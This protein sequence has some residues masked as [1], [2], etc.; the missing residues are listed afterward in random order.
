MT[1]WASSSYHSSNNRVQH[2]HPSL[3]CCSVNTTCNIYSF[4]DTS[5]SLLPLH[6]LLINVSVLIHFLPA[7]CLQMTSGCIRT[8]ANLSK[9][10][11]GLLPLQKTINSWIFVD[12]RS[13]V[14]QQERGIS[15]RG[16]KSNFS[17]PSLSI[18]CAVAEDMVQELGPFHYSSHIGYRGNPSWDWSKA[19]KSPVLISNDW[20]RDWVALKVFEAHFIK[21]FKPYKF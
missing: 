15:L 6:S 3:K 20:P 7:W 4:L 21:S 2:H 16:K 1:V 11:C 14:G 13:Y 10:L 5:A 12:C 8:C 18:C 19:D 9:P 17:L